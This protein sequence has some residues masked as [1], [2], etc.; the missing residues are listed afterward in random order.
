[1]SERVT[2]QLSK[3]KNTYR[4]VVVVGRGWRPSLTY[5][6]QFQ[7]QNIASSKVQFK[8]QPIYYS[9]FYQ[10]KFLELDIVTRYFDL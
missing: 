3:K 9:I 1:M 5:F 7:L 10:T 8:F 2:F 6:Y 4:V